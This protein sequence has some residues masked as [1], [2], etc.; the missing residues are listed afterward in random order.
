[1]NVNQLAQAGLVK[2]YSADDIIFYEGDLGKELYIILSGKVN[3]YI[4]SID[5]F[6]M[7]IAHLGPGDFFGEMSLLEDLPR[8][9]TVQAFENTIVLVIDESNFE[10]II[11]R[12]PK[13]ALGIMKGLSI[14][15]RQHNE[16]IRN[17]RQTTAKKEPP[18]QN[19]L[20]I[21]REPL[22]ENQAPEESKFPGDS[23][24]PPGHKSYPGK[25]SESD[26]SLLFDKNVTCPVCQ[27]NFGAKM[28]RSSKLKLKG[29]EPDFRQRFI[30]FEP[31]WYVVWVCPACYFANF[32]VEFPQVSAAAKKKIAQA[33]PQLKQQLAFEVTSPRKIDQVFTSFYLA[34][35]AAG[36]TDDA[37]KTAKIW[38]RLYWLYSDVNDPAMA[39]FAARQALTYYQKT[40]YETTQNTPLEQEQRLT[41]L[42]GELSLRNGEKDQA[43]NFFRS[44]IIRKGGSPHINQQARDRLYEL[45]QKQ[46]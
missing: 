38:L 33:A 44:A 37:A 23:L 25:A 43:F 34:L 45:K 5:G 17:L 36:F 39:D 8:S 11:S 35:H 21:S 29:I 46:Q 16:E 15:L 10:A 40:F 2:R 7:D 27:A 6:P 13:L 31:L 32:N 22:E 20:A 12:Q 14:R 28:I 4:N 9:A 1:M 41:Y 3:I 24:F 30:G 42:L 18:G 19:A 26:H